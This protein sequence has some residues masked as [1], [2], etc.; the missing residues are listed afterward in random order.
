[1][2]FFILAKLY[3]DARM[4]MILFE[5]FLAKVNIRIFVAKCYQ[6]REF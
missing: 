2:L 1:M 3:N 5:N 6:E 4:F